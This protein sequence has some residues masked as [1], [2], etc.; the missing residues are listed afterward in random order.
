MIHYLKPIIFIL[1]THL[2][3][4]QGSVNQTRIK[5]IDLEIQAALKKEDYAKAADLKR[6]KELREEMQ[7][8]LITEDY[9]K[10][11]QIKAQI[12]GGDSST[13]NNSTEINRLE[14]EM[15][16]AVNKEDYKRAGE[17]KRQIEILQSGGTINTTTSNTNTSFNS[18]NNDNGAPTLEFINQVYI[19]NKDGSVS[20]LEKADG[21]LIT[22]G[23]GYMVSSATSSYTLPGVASNVRVNQSNT[24]FVV[25]VFKGIDP[26]ENIKFLKFD[27]RGRRSP[28]RFA[29]QFKSTSA[30]YHSE[31]GAVTDQYIEISFKQITDEIYEVIV[32]NLAPAEYGFVYI[33]KFFA[34][35]IN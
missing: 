28:S 35:G 32:P 30:M 17:I 3:F 12:E 27:I 29:D 5:A 16:I 21:K 8:A 10:A 4:A 22:S 18:T 23:G 15:Q 31:T 2:A 9:A 6:E 1:F 25:K 13:S 14:K 33:N 34:F 7:K 11:A 20:P 19:W 26:S 24:R